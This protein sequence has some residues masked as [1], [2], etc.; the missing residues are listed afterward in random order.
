MIEPMYAFSKNKEEKKV[1][2]D[3]QSLSNV[4]FKRILALA[5]WPI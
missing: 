3:I 2:T 4:Y 5:M 1:I